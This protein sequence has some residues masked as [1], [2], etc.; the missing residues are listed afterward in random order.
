M[1]MLLCWHP[2]P[3]CL[4][5]LGCLQVSGKYKTAFRKPVESCECHTCRTHSLAYLHHLFK[6]R[7]LS[8]LSLLLLI[9]VL[10]CPQR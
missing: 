6:V 4:L 1:T 10:G 9:P 2:K 3:K 8:F 7:G 5:P